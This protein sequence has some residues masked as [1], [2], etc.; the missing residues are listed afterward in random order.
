[1]LKRYMMGLVLSLFLPISLLAQTG[2]EGTVTEADSNDP[3]SGATVVI[4]E[5]MQGTATD[6]N[7]YFQIEN[8]E[9]GNYTLRVTFIG[10]SEYRQ[11]VTIE[12]GEMLTAD[13]D[14]AIDAAGLDELIITGYSIRER[15]EVTGAISSVRA[16][17]ISTRAIQTADQALQGRSA[18]LQMVGASGA[19]GA[20]STIRIRGTG[21]INSGSTPLYIVDGVPMEQTFR[22]DIAGS[23]S[24]VLSAL[25]PSDIQAIDVCEMQKQQLF[26]GHKEQMV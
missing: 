8:I 6:A 21:S 20:T 24:N 4:E 5:T 2:V 23:S 14:L 15:R 10:F 16:E 26:M 19:P 1:M 18:G 9:P 11:E 7:G 13:I 17:Q 22:S 25:N 3:L 12:A